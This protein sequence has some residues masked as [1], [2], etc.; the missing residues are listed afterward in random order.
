[1]LTVTVTYT[2]KMGLYERETGPRPRVAEFDR[3]LLSLMEV[4]AQ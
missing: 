1:M 3:L 4:A 2:P